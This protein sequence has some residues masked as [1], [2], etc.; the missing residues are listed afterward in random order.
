MT[1]G[2][3]YAFIIHPGA[4]VSQIKMNYSG[5]VDKLINENGNIKIKS[6]FGD[7]IDHAPVSFYE[8][9][10]AAKIVSSFSLKKNNV[11]FS[12]LNY[13]KTKTVIIDPWSSVP[14]FTGYNGSY[15]CTFDYA[16]NMYVYGGVFPWQEIK[17]N[18]AGV[19][20][21]VYTCNR[22]WLLH[23]VLLWRFLC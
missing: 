17:F 15:D 22:F 16:G 10:S 21:W 11:S 1:S 9:T 6:S 4:D 14:T 5:E 12:L 20:Q 19:Q 13:D 23:G 2:I 7:I 8:N 3:K 18:N